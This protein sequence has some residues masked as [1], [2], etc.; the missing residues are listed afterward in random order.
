M[1]SIINDTVLGE[2]GIENLMCQFRTHLETALNILDKYFL[3]LI[4]HFNDNNY[5]AFSCLY[6]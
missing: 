3:G 4:I 2:R 6:A 1:T 5:A